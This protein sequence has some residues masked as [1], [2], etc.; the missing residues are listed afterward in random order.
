MLDLE[1]PS[2]SALRGVRMLI[3]QAGT[4]DYAAMMDETERRCKSWGYRY[5]RHWLSYDHE[6]LAGETPPCRFKPL[7][8]EG[9]PT[10][11]M[12]SA[13]WASGT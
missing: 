4:P 13:A 5:T 10:N 2:C 3:V 12:N 7:M 1:Q 6:D 9:I 8:L 11:W